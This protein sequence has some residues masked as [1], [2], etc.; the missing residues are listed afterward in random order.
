MR[1]LVSVF[2]ASLLAACASS[3]LSRAEKAALYD[4]YVSKTELEQVD[5]ITTFRLHSWTP[6]DN[7]RLILRTSPSRAY[8]LTLDHECWNL[9]FAH[10]IKINQSTEWTLDAKFDSI[11]VPDSASLKCHIKSIHK[12]TQDQAKELAKLDDNAKKA[13]Q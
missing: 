10:G 8:L 9:D 11:S 6:L 2:L 3:G 4:D 7:K 5:R 1:V 12:L 13:Q